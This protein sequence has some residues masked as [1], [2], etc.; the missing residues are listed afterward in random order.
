MRTLRVIYR[1]LRVVFLIYGL[2]NGLMKSRIWA[3][4]FALVRMLVGRRRRVRNVRRRAAIEFV[5]GSEPAIYRRQGWRRIRIE[6][7]FRR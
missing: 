4:A 5:D 2:V 6:D 3:V 1:T 7:G